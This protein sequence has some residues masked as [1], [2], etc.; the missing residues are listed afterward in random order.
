MAEA[1]REGIGETGLRRLAG[2]A[3]K[4]GS[5]DRLAALP[6]AR[7]PDGDYR[8]GRAADRSCRAR[9][10]AGV[11]RYRVEGHRRRHRQPGRYASG[12]RRGRERGAA[13]RRQRDAIRDLVMRDNPDG[14]KLCVRTLAT[15][16]VSGTDAGRACFMGDDPAEPIRVD[17]CAGGDAIGLQTKARAGRRGHSRVG[18]PRCEPGSGP[19]QGSAR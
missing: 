6:G 13:A 1:A 8:P 18:D 14:S 17:R 16:R 5:Q 9:S 11:P 2:P 4:P 12:G 19:A 3:R 10:G 15:V 7:H